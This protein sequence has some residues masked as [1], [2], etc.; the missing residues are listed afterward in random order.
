MRNETATVSTTTRVGSDFT[1]V[2]I[3]MFCPK[4]SGLLLIKGFEFKGKGHMFFLCSNTE[5]D[6]WLPY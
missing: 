3:T 6:F 4:C 5:C 2:A 1:E